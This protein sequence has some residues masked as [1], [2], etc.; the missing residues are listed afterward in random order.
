MIDDLSIDVIIESFRHRFIVCSS[1][2]VPGA[3]VNPRLNARRL[4]E[5]SR[6]RPE[7]PCSSIV[8]LPLLE[9]RRRAESVRKVERRR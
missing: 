2:Q 6:F 8:T 4:I 1:G 3:L 9:Q 7:L 5:N